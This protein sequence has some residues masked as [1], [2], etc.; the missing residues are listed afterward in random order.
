MIFG[1]DVTII[2]ITAHIWFSE[3]E[4]AIATIITKQNL[5]GQVSHV[6]F[7]L[8]ISVIVTIT[9]VQIWVFLELALK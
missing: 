9:K 5:R 3:I 1:I 8:G 7:F 6:I 2:I 4:V